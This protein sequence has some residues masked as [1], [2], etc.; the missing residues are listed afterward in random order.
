MVPLRTMNRPCGWSPTSTRISP[1]F[2]ARRTLFASRRASCA[3]VSLGNI[4]SRRFS[5]RLVDMMISGSLE[6]QH[7]LVH[8]APAPILAR[9]ERADDGM[10]RRVKVLGGVA[11]LGIVAAADVAAGA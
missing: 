5:R 6:L 4:C 3:G 9:L 7:H 10:V 11:V 2:V 1:A 8:K